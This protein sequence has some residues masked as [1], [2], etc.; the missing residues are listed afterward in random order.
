MS[1]IEDFVMPIIDQWENIYSYSNPYTIGEKLK[2]DI[3]DAKKGDIVLLGYLDNRIN[4][5]QHL[6]ETNLINIRKELYKLHDLNWDFSF[7]DIGNIYA[8]ETYYDSLIA[9]D[10]VLNELI[11]LEVKIILFGGNNTL[12]TTIYN[13]LKDDNYLHFTQISPFLGLSDYNEKLT[14]YNFLTKILLDEPCK[15]INYTSIANQNFLNQ[16]IFKD[17]LNVLNFESYRLGELNESL[18][19]CEPILRTSDFA[20]F[21]L[22]AI[23]NRGEIFQSNPQPNGISPLQ[24]CALARFLGSSEFLKI[25]HFSNFIYSE[26]NVVSDKLLAQIIWHNLEGNQLCNEILKNSDKKTKY[27]LFLENE[28]LIFYKE[29]FSGRWWMECIMNQETGQKYTIP[30]Q[31]NDYL[32]AFSGE[33]PDRYLKVF[34]KFL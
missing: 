20:N 1:F 31:E 32:K 34:K 22:N 30:S 14:E 5:D 13:V 9:L 11:K 26:N 21:D 12:N 33:L 4:F 15:I 8:G 7:F 18:I 16:P 24:A 10:L 19:G 29:Q 17:I 6:K 2:F 23:E 27:T 25:L 28:E 3:N